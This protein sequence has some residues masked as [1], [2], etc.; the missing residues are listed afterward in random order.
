MLAMREVKDA[1]RY[2]G[3]HQRHDCLPPQST[4]IISKNLG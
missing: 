2:E 1:C 4:E 3:P